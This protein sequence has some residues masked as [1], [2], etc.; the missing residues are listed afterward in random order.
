ML[1]GVVELDLL[2]NAPG[3]LRVKGFVEG[4]T[5]TRRAGPGHQAPSSHCVF[6]RPYPQYRLFLPN[7]Q[8]AMRQ[9]EAKADPAPVRRGREAEEGDLDRR[10]G[11]W[12][13][14]TGKPPGTRESRKSGAM[15]T[16]PDRWT[17]GGR[18]LG[19]RDQGDLLTTKN[20]EP[21]PTH[22]PPGNIGPQHCLHRD[23]LCRQRESRRLH[24]S[25]T[26]CAH[27]SRASA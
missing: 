6:R 1:R 27:S 18:W 11:G 23:R 17:R 14:I 4:R 15:P 26:Q 3:F 2:S 25:T 20:A 16:G 13:R 22:R 21:S 5:L 10:V 7:R 19:Q 24:A 9:R 12:A 8:V